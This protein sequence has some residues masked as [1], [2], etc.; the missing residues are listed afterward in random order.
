MSLVSIRD[1]VPRSTALT[2]DQRVPPCHLPEHN[3]DSG[4]HGYEVC[5][6]FWSNDVLFHLLADQLR[7]P[8]RTDPAHEEARVREDD[9]L[10]P[11]NSGLRR[12]DYA[13]RRH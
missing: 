2:T 1:I 3:Q 13:S 11:R 12:L 4:H 9:S 8:V 7:I 5:T 6:Q 10:F